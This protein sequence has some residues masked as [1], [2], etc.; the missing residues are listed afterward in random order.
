MRYGGR[1]TTR[2]RRLLRRRSLSGA[3]LFAVVLLAVHGVWGRAKRKGDAEAFQITTLQH[4]HSAFRNAVETPAQFLT[5]RD[6]GIITTSGA[7]GLVSVYVLIRVLRDVHRN[8]LPIQVWHYNELSD[9]DCA[10]FRSF[11]NVSCP[12]LAR[13]MP[14]HRGTLEGYAIK[15]LAMV[16]CPF[17]H[18]IFIDLDNVPA[19]DPTALLGSPE[20]RRTG[21]LFWPDLWVSKVAPTGSADS[22]LSGLRAMAFLCGVRDE[23]LASVNADSVMGAR[24]RQGLFSL[25]E[26]GQLVIDRVRHQRALRALRFLNLRAHITYRMVQGD[27]D[28]FLFAWLGTNSSFTMVSARAVPVGGT[29]SVRGSDSVLCAHTMGQLLPASLLSDRTM[30]PFAFLH[31]NYHSKWHYG[32]HLWFRWS[33]VAIDTSPAA[34][35]AIWLDTDIPHSSCQPAT[36]TS[37][38]P[39]SHRWRAQL[40]ALEQLC[41]KFVVEYPSAY[42]GTFHL[43]RLAGRW[44]SLRYGQ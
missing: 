13:S 26:S 10:V 32:R 16:Y 19:V 42:P 21:A 3:I 33:A 28:T 8:D 18:A 37:T 31:R 27:K 4:L 40:E 38:T 23:S 14:E 1:P 6:A 29:F 15:A 34:N 2:F 9:E 25:F 35:A 43:G 22:A 36:I 24:R 12:N 41:V 20:Y 17:R 7:G 44:L 30:L 11:G 39:A 5:G